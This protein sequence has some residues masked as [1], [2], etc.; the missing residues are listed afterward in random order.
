MGPS[1]NTPRWEIGTASTHPHTGTTWTR[2]GLSSATSP[3]RSQSRLA[4]CPTC[5]SRRTMVRPLLWPTDRFRC[6]LFFNAVASLCDAMP[7]QCHAMPGHADL[8]E[9][10]FVRRL[11]AHRPAAC[12]C[13]LCLFAHG[14]RRRVRLGRGLTVQLP[15]PRAQGASQGCGEAQQVRQEAAAVRTAPAAVR[16]FVGAAKGNADRMVLARADSLIGKSIIMDMYIICIHRFQVG[17]C[18]SGDSGHL[19]CA[20]AGSRPEGLETSLMGHTG[21][22]HGSTRPARRTLTGGSSSRATSRTTR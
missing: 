21:G 17:G 14:A 2:S 1:G 15:Q 8:R 9:R 6:G 22:R 13:L 19:M 18:R 5:P 11:S 3:L 4:W 20:C 16:S 12:V 7:G 10:S